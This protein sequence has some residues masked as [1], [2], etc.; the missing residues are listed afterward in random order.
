MKNIIIKITHIIF[1]LNNKGKYIIIAD[2]LSII[3]R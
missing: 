3:I 2:I 1:Q